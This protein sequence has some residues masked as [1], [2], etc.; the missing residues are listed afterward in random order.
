MAFSR[1]VD[2]DHVLVKAQDSIVVKVGVVL[3]GIR[4]VDE[5]PGV[6]MRWPPGLSRLKAPRKARSTGGA[7]CSK[8]SLEI[9]KSRV[10]AREPSGAV[11]SKNG[12]W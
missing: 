6:R 7:T 3:Q 11:M 4:V 12:S 2:D 5:G 9:T 8:T 1:S 10:P